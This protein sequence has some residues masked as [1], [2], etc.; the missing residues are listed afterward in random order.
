MELLK[1][2]QVGGQRNHIL[3]CRYANIWRMF[4]RGFQKLIFVHVKFG[5]LVRCSTI[6]VKLADGY[7]GLRPRKEPWAKIMNSSAAKSGQKN[8]R[9]EFVASLFGL[10]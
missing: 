3:E 1:I 5:M 8:R 9:R 2:L 7:V 10:L 6:D 4:E